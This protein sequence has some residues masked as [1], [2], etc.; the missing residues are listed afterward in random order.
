FDDQGRLVATDEVGRSDA[1]YDPYL[2]AGLDAGTYYVGV[3][4]T[5]N[6]PGPAGGYDPATGDA[7]SVPQSQP[8]GSFRLIVVADPQDPPRA[9]P[10]PQ[11]P[12]RRG[13]RPSPPPPSASS[14]RSI[15]YPR[16]WTGR[17]RSS[18]RAAGPGRSWRP[19]TPRR[20]PAFRTS[21][22][23]GSPPAVTPSSSP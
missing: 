16:P 3:S 15:P 19:P 7:G 12:P 4:G 2:F 9:T 21:S 23:S 6:L 18:T 17:S 10:T 1:P 20:M 13:P 14:A 8:G 22:A 11:A 5:G